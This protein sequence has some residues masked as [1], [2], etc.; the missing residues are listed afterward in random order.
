MKQ[1]MRTNNKNKKNK[2]RDGCCIKR[3]LFFLVPEE[4]K[5]VSKV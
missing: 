5:T 3:K 4:P 2:R 1:N